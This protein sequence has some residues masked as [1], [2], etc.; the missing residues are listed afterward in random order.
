MQIVAHFQKQ[1]CIKVI[2]YLLSKK[3]F[4]FLSL[5]YVQPIKN[6]IGLKTYSD[7]RNFSQKLCIE[8]K[9]DF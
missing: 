9:I 3:N 2:F 8:T 5:L 1:I 7:F 4:P 6:M